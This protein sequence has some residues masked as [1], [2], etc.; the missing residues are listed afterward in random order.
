MKTSLDSLLTSSGTRLS[1]QVVGVGLTIVI[2]TLMAAG[3]LAF[4]HQVS[5]VE[6]R[7]SLIESYR[8]GHD[9]SQ[10][11]SLL[12]EAET[13][14]RGYLLSGQEHFV[15]P[16]K[17]AQQ[18][19]V[20]LFE[21]V[22]ASSAPSVQD[23]EELRQLRDLAAAKM[24]ELAESIALMKSGRKEE[25]VSLFQRGMGHATFHKIRAVAEVLKESQ[26]QERDRRSEQLKEYTDVAIRALLALLFFSVASLLGCGLLLT[27]LFKARTRLSEQAVIVAR[28]ATEATD[29]LTALFTSMD[30]G[31]FSTGV[32][33]RITFCNGSAEKLALASRTEIVGRAV[34]DF[35]Y[36]SNGE[37]LSEILN[38]EQVVQNR[39]AARQIALNL[40]RGLGRVDS[41]VD[42]SLGDG[43]G[44]GFLP[45]RL[46]ATPLVSE[47]EAAGVLFT[48]LDR[49][50]EAEQLR[51]A[52]AQNEISSI[53]AGAL[54][55]QETVGRIIQVICRNF[56]FDMGRVWFVDEHQLALI[57][58][59]VFTSQSKPPTAYSRPT[60]E[61]SMSLSQGLQALVHSRRAPVWVS[62]ISQV[63]SVVAADT[64]PPGVIS[65]GCRSLLGVPILAGEKFLGLME[66]GSTQILEED[67]SLSAIFSG[68]AVQMGQFIERV[69][70][71]ELLS[72]SEQRYS[73][74]VEGTMDGIWDWDLKQGKVYWSKRW[75]EMLG[76][77]E[78]LL[79]GAIET[80]YDLVH[81]DDLPTVKKAQDAHINGETDI[82][83][84][85]FRLRTRDGEYRWFN[86][87]GV[88]VRNELGQV[89]R[90]LG[91]NRDITNEIEAN[92]KLKQSERKFRA[93][94]NKT[95]EFIGLL[96]PE[97]RLIDANH[98]A[99]S[100]VG[101]SIGE[102]YNQYFWDCPWWNHNEALQKRLQEAVVKAASGSFDRFEAEHIGSSGRIFID[103]SLQPVEDES[104]R[105]IFLIP[106][107][108]DITAVKEAQEKLRESEAMFRRLAENIRSI[109]WIA[110]PDG[111]QLIYLSPAY[112][113]I[114]GGK[115]ADA[116]LEASSF[117][118]HVLPEDR[119]I[120]EA[121]MTGT[122]AAAEF[123]MLAPDG[124]PNWLSAR[125]FPV[126]DAD[127]AVIQICGVAN[128]IRDRKE[129]EKRVSEFYST[130]SHELRSPLTSIRGS[131]GLIEGGLVGEISD[132][133]R[134]FITIAR[135]E[136][137]RLIRLI[138]SILD[139]RKIEAGKL[140]IYPEPLN[141]LEL[142]QE[143][144]SACNG[145]AQE[146]SVQIEIG[147][148]EEAT[149]SADVDR[150]TQVLTNLIAN[151]VKFSP[152]ATS[153]TVSGEKV[154]GFY[155]YA[156]H[157]QG[158]GI[159]VKDQAR[160]FG[161]FQQL[162]STDSRSKGGSGLGLAISKA[163]VEQHGG[164]IG[165]ESEPGKGSCFWFKLPA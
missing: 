13:A 5:M 143:T 128:D 84:C 81:P 111:S 124:E 94:F 77:E 46:T 127:G 144:V 22:T 50:I 86:T 21:K 161:K 119:Q 162:D 65:A 32:D 28:Q 140:D 1:T 23:R 30:E 99:L 141:T 90:L 95:F 105:V 114:T 66:F 39:Q 58:R 85:Q 16:Y 131:L 96:T 7:S 40:R 107:G 117:Y 68:I 104:G 79:D 71:Q 120:A 15:G 83:T 75:M 20:P 126:C 159:S 18:E 115:I 36:G 98:S 142:V 61:R 38:L 43:S 12:Q 97:G 129:A 116:L 130:V 147:R 26:R 165:V 25:A 63:D 157:D 103:F 51:R 57:C 29:R 156:V 110:T 146:A 93:I 91:T 149:I 53:M 118:D 33:G 154:D 54:T 151:A 87:R 24:D 101:A 44:L 78:G 48:F 112:E 37:S 47:G 137:D 76:Y 45:V 122:R 27:L 69:Q 121:V 62:D 108:R 164:E 8:F 153:V 9:L 60:A 73:L 138:N 41:G 19:L 92:E 102:L 148:I 125:A 55:M 67:S 52:E 135:S 3:F 155:R 64:L 136:S 158:P 82:Y 42:V 35:F 70:V 152:P 31:V 17:Q 2:V 150:I 145:M 109:F 80:F 10:I 72:L 14:E 134:A 59:F 100:F 4:Q 34:S 139:L 160:L 106:E 132:E 89:V 123:R 113:S 88:A 74:A 6:F 56:N 163:L 11:I 133:A 49:S